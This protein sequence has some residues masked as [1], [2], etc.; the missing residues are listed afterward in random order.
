MKMKSAKKSSQIKP[1]KG[2]KQ[3]D[4][5]IVKTESELEEGLPEVYINGDGLS[6]QVK[7]EPHSQ[8]IS[9]ELNGD[10]PSSPDTKPDVVTPRSDVYHQYKQAHIKEE[11]DSDHLPEYE[12]F[13]AA[14]KE[15]SES[16]IKE[17]RDGYEE[18]EERGEVCRGKGH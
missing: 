16:W 17:E 18:A 7:E 3:K 6:I 1:K 9:V 4:V 13:E 11:C 5:L 2:D 15:E 10:P 12:F 14:V 8:E